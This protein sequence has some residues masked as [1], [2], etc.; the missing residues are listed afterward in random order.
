MNR[1]EIALMESLNY[2]G[3]TVIEGRSS[4]RYAWGSLW[5]AGLIGDEWGTLPNGRN[6]LN[7]LMEGDLASLPSAWI[8]LQNSGTYGD[9]LWSDSMMSVFVSDRFVAAIKDSGF[10]GY[11][12]LPLEVEPKRGER[13]G[14]YSLLL[15]DNRDHDAPIRSFPFPYRATAHLDVSA[16]VMAALT[17]AG[18]TG[19]LADDAST[20]AAAVL[21]AD[22]A[23]P[24]D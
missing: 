4:A 16:E 21:A 23:D 20:R 6:V 2:E 9:M 24:D 3:R 8:K 19:F 18:V 15:P 11:Q 10:G 12:L 17:T 7:T 22:D 13:F 5:W 1:S 14:G